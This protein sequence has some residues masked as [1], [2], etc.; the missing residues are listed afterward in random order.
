MKRLFSF[1]IVAIGLAFTAQ[2]QEYHEF[3]EKTTQFGLSFRSSFSFVPGNPSSD[4]ATTNLGFKIDITPG[5]YVSRDFTDYFKLLAEPAYS[6]SVNFSDDLSHFIKIPV[7]G[8]FRVGRGYIGAGLQQDIVFSAPAGMKNYNQNA[9]SAFLEFCYFTRFSRSG[10]W[11]Y[12]SERGFHPII[13][14]GCSLNKI[15]HVS[16]KGHYIFAEGVWR[17]NFLDNSDASGNSK[18]INRKRR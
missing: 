18:S 11:S 15:G 12:Y 1:A 10:N 6:L 9:F 2:S 8:L 16:N 13:R 4:W 7:A 14:L 3:E 17:F 5:L